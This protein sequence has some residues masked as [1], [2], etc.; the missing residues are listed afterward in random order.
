MKAHKERLSLARAQGSEGC[1]Y[2]TTSS[3]ALAFATVHSDSDSTG[4]YGF[5]VAEAAT[6]S[7]VT[8]KDRGGNALTLTPTWKSVSLPAGSWIT[9]GRITQEDAYIATV[10]VSAGVIILYID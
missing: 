5:W 9:A 2:H 7:A 1:D 4:W 3:D 8:F 6:L 10:T